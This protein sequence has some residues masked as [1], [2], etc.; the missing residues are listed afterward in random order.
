MSSMVERA[1][2]FYLEHSDVVDQHNEPLGQTHRVYNCPACESASVIRNG[3]MVSLNS[4]PSLVDDDSLSIQR[5]A[6]LH[7]SNVEGNDPDSET[8][9]P[10]A[11]LTC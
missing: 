2:A 3:E 5:A 1:L 7:R 11:L 10:E 9:D 8:S 6:S 4:S